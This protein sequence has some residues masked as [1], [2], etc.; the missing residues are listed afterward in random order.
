MD[1][2][3]LQVLHELWDFVSYFRYT[4]CDSLMSDGNMLLRTHQWKFQQQKGQTLY[5][6]QSLITFTNFIIINIPSGDVRL[7]E[8]I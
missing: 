5:R 8:K 4:C 1:F 3:M 6:I 7:C 2:A